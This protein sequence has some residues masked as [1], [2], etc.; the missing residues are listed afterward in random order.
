MKLSDLELTRVEFTIRTLGEKQHD[1]TNVHHGYLSSRGIIPKDWEIGSVSTTPSFFAIEYENGV[2]L[3][4]NEMMF[5]VS[6]EDDVE[7]GETSASLDLIVKYLLATV[8]PDVFQTARAEI[9][10]DLPKE[11]SRNWLTEHFIHPEVTPSSWN[12]VE[13]VIMAGFV[14]DELSIRLRCMSDRQTA[15]QDED[16]MIRVSI[17]LLPDNFSND[18]ELIQWWSNW[19]VHENAILKNVAL[20]LGL[21]DDYA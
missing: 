8:S 21:E 2:R 5:Q 6:Q 9:E 13:F 14:V 4:G 17:F 16:D 15:N 11:D 18:K 1:F 10:L 7:V 19:T 20:L 12:D 3:F